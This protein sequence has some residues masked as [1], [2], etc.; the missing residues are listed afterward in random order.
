MGNK[1][2]LF[3]PLQNAEPMF[4]KNHPDLS[5][6]EAKKLLEEQRTRD[7]QSI[8]DALKA[9]KNVAFLEYGDPTIYGSWIYWLQD[10]K[11]Y[12]EVIPG[13]SAFN[14]SNAL[15]NKHF[16]CNGSIILTVPKGLKSNEAMLKAIAENGDT[17]VIFIGLK[18]MKELMPV[19]EKYYSPS[20]PVNLV[21]RSGYSDSERLIKTTLSEVLNV[22]EGEKEKHLGMIYIGPCLK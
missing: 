14:A 17:L 18:E 22:E 8:K 15:I 19:F 1:P 3:D 11:D 12:I 6:V 16:G 2:I 13:I 5:P 21:Y 10:L 9:G 20:T 4:M 7:I